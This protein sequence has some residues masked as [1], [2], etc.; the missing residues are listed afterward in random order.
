MDL[1]IFRQWDSPEELS[2]RPVRTLFDRVSDLCAPPDVEI[3]PYGDAQTGR[4]KA[5]RYPLPDHVSPPM[6]MHQVI[7]LVWI[8]RDPLDVIGWRHVDAPDELLTDFLRLAKGTDEQVAD[9]ARRWGPLWLCSEHEVCA[10]ERIWTGT[11]CIW[12][13]MEPIAAWRREAQYAKA[14]LDIATRL[15]A[16]PVSYEYWELLDIDQEMFKA[17]K[18]RGDRDGQAFWLAVLVQLKL[19][20]P[21]Q[22][23]IGLFG[24]VPPVANDTARYGMFLDTGPGFLAAVWHQVALWL[25]RLDQVYICDGCDIPY[26]RAVRKPRPD[27]SNF[28]PRCRKRNKGSKR[29]WAQRERDRLRTRD[30]AGEDAQTTQ[31]E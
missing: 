25:C 12:P 30:L 18:V 14:V 31:A 20:G 21:M 5:L 9:F 28:C 22:P 24:H 3:V 10:L 15:N 19:N 13:G 16:A 6:P 2:E 11:E 26:Q 4:E 23:R 1:R 8:D 7:K 29:L 27:Q 17:M